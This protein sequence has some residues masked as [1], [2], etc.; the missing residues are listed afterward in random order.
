MVYQQKRIARDIA[1]IVVSIIGAVLIATTE[2]LREFLTSAAEIKFL[3]SFL[4]GMFF[5]SIFTAAP[6]S[7]VLVEIA[8]S[9]SLFEVAFFGGLGAMVG[10]L[11]IFRFIKDDLA[12][13]IRWLIGKNRER[14]IASIFKLHH[15]RW[16]IHF[17][18]ALVVASPLPD[19]LGLAMM[20]LSKMRMALFI[21][22]SFVLNFFGI[23]FIALIAKGLF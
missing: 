9:N 15:S 7:V 19:E 16:L 5:I 20:G 21:P 1:I 11:I 17:L 18:G 13:D 4:A 14:R 12:E 22:L 8:L 6:A 23:L 2:S 10:D 3:G